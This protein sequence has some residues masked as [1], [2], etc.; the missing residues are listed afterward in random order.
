M[1][2][3]AAV[4]LAVVAFWSARVVSAAC[5]PPDLLEA[6][7]PSGSTVPANAALFAHYA[8]TAEY[9]NEDVLLDS[10]D[11]VGDA[12]TVTFDSTQGLLEFAPAG[13]LPPGTYTIHW[14]SLRGLNVAAPG[15]GADVRFTVTAATDDAPPTFDGLTA[16]RWDLER[17]HNDCTDALENRFVFDLDLAPADDDGGRGGLSLV[18]FQTA[19][20]LSDGGSVP[21]LTEAMPAAGKGATVKLPVADATGHVCF[22]ALARDLTDKTSNG[23][24]HVVCADTT[25]PPFFRGCAIAGRDAGSGAGASLLVLGAVLIARARRARPR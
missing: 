18:V 22:S 24:S 3:A 23:A 1:R 20:A 21:V 8:S 10:P 13:G 7:P 6:I 25:A 16:V 12:V 19:G 9:A 14:P 5:A 4:A 2:R 11:H 15:K 17:A